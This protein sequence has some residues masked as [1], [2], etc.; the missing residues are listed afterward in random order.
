MKKCY[1]CAEDIQE[2]AKKC[3]HCGE[4]IKNNDADKSSNKK[5]VKKVIQPTFT[6]FFKDLFKGRLNRRNFFLG[7]FVVFVVNL[8]ITGIMDSLYYDNQDS[9]II[10]ILSYLEVI[11]FFLLYLSL[12]VRRLHD[13]NR[14]GKNIFWVFITIWLIVIISQKGTSTANKY[15]EAQKN[16]IGFFEIIFNIKRSEVS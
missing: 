15:G 14:S 12:F 4:W 6:S 10:H 1:Y 16:K 5:V 7:L 8:I 3:K 9:I 11:I 2:D 13:T